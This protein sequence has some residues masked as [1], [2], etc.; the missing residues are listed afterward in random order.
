MTNNLIIKTQINIIGN[1]L[2]RLNE[3]FYILLSNPDLINNKYDA[4]QL[5]DILQ[6]IN[7]TADQLE[8]ITQKM[9]TN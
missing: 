3:A 7:F 6:T 5:T 9:F 8:C 2:E 4:D 1:E